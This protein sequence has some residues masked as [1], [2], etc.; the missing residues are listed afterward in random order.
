MRWKDDPRLNIITSVLV[1]ETQNHQRK[2][3][4]KGRR[5]EVCGGGRVPATHVA[6]KVKEGTTS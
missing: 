2:N 6:L 5:E 3:V 4:T 1:R